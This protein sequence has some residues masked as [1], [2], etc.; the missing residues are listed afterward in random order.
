M[1]DK[2]EII[3]TIT[4]HY[5]IKVI[6][7]F[8][9]IDGSSKAV[10]VTAKALNEI[11][12]YFEPAFFTGNLYVV[13]SLDEN[14]L[15]D[16][17]A[18]AIVYDKNVLLNR[19]NG[20]L[21]IQ[22][23]EDESIYLWENTA[24]DSPETITNTLIYHYHQNQEFFYANGEKID[25]TITKRGSRFATQFEDLLSTLKDYENNKV[26]HSSCSYF[27]QCWQDANR[28]FFVG[29][30]S[31]SNVPEKYIQESLAEYLSTA[32]SRGIK[33]E[34]VRE[35]NIVADYTKPKPVDVK[36]TWREANRIA[37][38][39]TKFLGMVKPNSGGNAYSYDDPR[40]NAGLKQVKEYHDKILADVPTTMIK[41]HLLVV[42]GRRN[43]LTAAQTTI[44]YAD[45]MYY[46]DVDITVD[47]DKRYFD[48][49]PGFEKPIKVFA[50]PVT[51]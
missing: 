3:R 18:S 14:F 30:G 39:E 44:S 5:V 8:N 1:P 12:R 6:K 25:I 24:V 22:I 29:G 4:K 16:K 35:Y 50:A 37:I 31:G 21:V 9:E 47:T 46:K 15:L 10:E 41:S 13:K 36:I 19:L 2:E 45:G 42:D 26:M 33:L 43:N 17:T 34:T 7:A 11:Y 48:S 27:N 49:V 23:F 32:L 51:V 40:A 20:N 38:I 28:L